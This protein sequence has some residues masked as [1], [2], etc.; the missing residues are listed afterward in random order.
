MDLFSEQ[1]EK[2]ASVF[3]MR[4]VL[5]DWS[6]QK[7]ITILKHTRAAAQPDTRLLILDTLLSYAVPVSTAFDVPEG[8]PKPPVPLL[9]N[10]GY[11]GIL[12]YYMDMMVKI[13]SAVYSSVDLM[14]SFYR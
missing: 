3:F 12:P 4:M 1:P 10:G 7:C 8:T 6:D 13:Q 11:A 2:N 5:H 14:H 9:L